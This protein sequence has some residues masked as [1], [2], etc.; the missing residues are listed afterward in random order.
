M[1]KIEVQS[2]E[3]VQFLEITGRIAELLGQS[4]M[5][6]GICHVYVPHTTAAVTINENADPDVMRDMQVKLAALIPQ[7]TGFRHAE[8]NSDA[9]IKASLCGFSVTIPVVGRRLQLG[10]W[11]GV[12]F[13]EFDGPRHRQLYVT[14]MGNESDNGMVRLW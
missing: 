1:L 10:T 3:R 12:Y 6:E 5:N 14:L 11:Q 4:G 8:G 7:W 9:H 13:C 2:K